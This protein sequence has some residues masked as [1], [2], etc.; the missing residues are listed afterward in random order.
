MSNNFI[1][2]IYA[3]V[4]VKEIITKLNLKSQISKSQ[5]YI[6]DVYGRNW[7]SKTSFVN[8]DYLKVLPSDRQKN[9]SNN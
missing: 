2:F 4:Y 5:V 3:Y 9:E 7:T 8:W 6:K 1:S